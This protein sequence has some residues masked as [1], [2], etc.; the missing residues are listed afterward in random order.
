MFFEIGKF[1][2][3]TASFRY[4]KDFS[5]PASEC[6][7]A[8]TRAGKTRTEALTIINAQIGVGIGLLRKAATDLKRGSRSSKT[9]A[10][11]LK[12]FRVNPEFVPTWFKPTN[13][14]RDRGDVVATRCSRVADM[15]ASGALKFFCT[16]NS[17]NCP[18]CPNNANRFACSSWGDES[19]V[20]ARSR[21]V[22]LGHRFWDDMKANRTTSMLSTL[23]HEPFHIYY[24]KYVTAH[25]ADAGKF[26]GVNCILQFV[27]E[28]NGRVAPDR[29]NKGCTDMAV[30]SE[31]SGY[32]S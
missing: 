13:A 26:G 10:I 14:I 18:D 19:K 25:R 9:R 3:A 15:L 23:M 20:P 28:T 1:S 12:I 8:L 17:T 7:A 11:F 24:G 29:V 27:F 2:P 4:V 30:R 31:I 5:G 21:V 16:V 6:V 32:S 22:C